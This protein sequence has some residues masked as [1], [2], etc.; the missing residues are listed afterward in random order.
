MMGWLS[1]ALYR[2]SDNSRVSMTPRSAQNL[3]IAMKKLVIKHLNFVKCC[4]KLLTL[5]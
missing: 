2:D 5:S 4:S 1:R 3:N